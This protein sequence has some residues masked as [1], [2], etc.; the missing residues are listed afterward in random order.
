[1]TTFTHVEIS[2]RV[3]GVGY[4]AWCHGEATHRGLSGWVRNRRSG[5]VE[6]V[7]SGEAAGVEDMLSALWTGPS[8]ATVTAIDATPSQ[9]RPAEGFILRDTV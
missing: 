6:A 4:R 9:E 3:Q 2:G 5:T 8:G 7:F 1:M